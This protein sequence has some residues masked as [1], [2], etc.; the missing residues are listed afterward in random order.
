MPLLSKWNFEFAWLP[1]GPIVHDRQQE[2]HEAINASNA[3]ES[4]T[5]FIGFIISA[6]KASRILIEPMSM[7]DKMS[8]ISRVE[9]RSDGHWGYRGMEHYLTGI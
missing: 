2:Y 9:R 5:V 1:V 3:A 7:R 4:S 8:D 6:I